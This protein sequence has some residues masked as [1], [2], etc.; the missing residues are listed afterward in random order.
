[1]DKM[2]LFEESHTAAMSLV[3]HCCRLDV[4]ETQQTAAALAA[5]AIL[6]EELTELFKEGDSASAL[7]R[8]LSN[9]LMQRAIDLAEK[10]E[11]EG[12]DG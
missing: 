4:T 2:E 1:M 7:G 10:K 12:K 11:E 3:D 8:A 6:C 9:V 5:I